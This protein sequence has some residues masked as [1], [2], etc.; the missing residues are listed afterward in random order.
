MTCDICEDRPAQARWM[1]EPGLMVHTC[2][3]CLHEYCQ[4]QDTNRPIPP[5]ECAEAVEVP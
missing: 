4:P 5:P 1:P 2:W 3:T